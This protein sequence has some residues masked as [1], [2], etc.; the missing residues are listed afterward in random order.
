MGALSPLLSLVKDVK[1]S[2]EYWK[3]YRGEDIVI[4]SV[5][6]S[7]M[8]GRIKYGI[9]GTVDE[10]QSMPPGFILKDAD[11]FYNTETFETGQYGTPIEGHSLTGEHHDKIF[12]SFDSINRISFVQDEAVE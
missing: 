3:T 8:E 11:E 5:E 9:T 4:Q 6:F 7:E 1:K 2:Y 10:V 12:V